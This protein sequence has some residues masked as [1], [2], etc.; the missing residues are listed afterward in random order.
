MKEAESTICT[1][2]I[3][4]TESS[5]CCKMLQNCAFRVAKGM[6]WETSF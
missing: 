3:G 4:G 1:A 5:K 6:G 2:N